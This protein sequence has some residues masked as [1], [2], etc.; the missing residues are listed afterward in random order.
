M[1]P[2]QFPHPNGMSTFWTEGDGDIDNIRSTDHLPS[3]NAIV[4]IGGGYSAASLLT[5]ILDSYPKHP[6][7]VVIEARQLCSGATGRNGGH[8]KPDLYASPSRIGE[9]FGSTAAEELVEFEA[10]N[11][12]AVKNFVEKEKIQC[13]MVLTRATDVVFTEK[14]VEAATKG[15][16]SLRDAGVRALDDVWY[17]SGTEAAMVSGVK[18]AKGC[19]TYTAGHIWPYK[20]VHHMFRRALERGVNI[21]TNTR[22]EHLSTA[23][24]ADGWWKISTNRG[25]LKA[26]KIVIATN[27]YTQ[28]LLPEYKDRIIPYRAV[29]C[30]ITTPKPAPLLTNTYSLKFSEW[31]FDYLIPR[32]DGSIIVGGAR[33]AYFADKDQWYGN[34][35]DSTLIDGVRKYFDGYMQ[36]HFRGWEQSDASVKE[37]WTGIMGYSCDKV[38]RLGPIPGK[39]GLFV[40]G[41]WTGHG[42]PQIFLAAKGMADMVVG[43]V[44]YQETGLPRIFE[45]T[46]IR[47]KNGPNKVLDSWR[48][49]TGR[50]R[51]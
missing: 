1:S 51:L 33:S 37:I 30:H 46:E 6:S 17:T 24:D 25:V 27:A 12:R 2:G 7:V 48:T 40:M 13:E 31:D 23:A 3:E 50:S 32:K 45:E 41:G 10:N 44:S 35:D 21:Q 8:L 49:S 29:S 18:D 14:Q 28:A 47:L 26:K 4:I 36:R 9:V 15:I 20:L 11:V 34:V 16:Q 42:M 43:G 38:P 19:F 39:E 22:V 5:H